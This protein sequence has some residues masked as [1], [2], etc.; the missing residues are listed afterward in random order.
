MATSGSPISRAWWLRR[1]RV[2]AAGKEKTAAAANAVCPLGGRSRHQSSPV[3]A[4]SSS[5]SMVVPAARSMTWASQVSRSPVLGDRQGQAELTGVRGADGGDQRADQD[6][7]E[8]QGDPR[9]P[10]SATG[11]QAARPVPAVSRWGPR[12]SS[13]FEEAGGNRHG[14]RCSGRLR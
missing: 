2:S 11:G 10:A 5:H 6:A 3:A 12:L 9:R 8:H 4:S 7:D 13:A 1:C 14:P